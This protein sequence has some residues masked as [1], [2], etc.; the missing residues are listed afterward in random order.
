MEEYSLDNIETEKPFLE[1]VNFVELIQYH[2][3]SDINI[4]F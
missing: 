4:V 1:I 3:V 2:L